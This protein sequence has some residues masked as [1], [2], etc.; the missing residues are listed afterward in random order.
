M[1]RLPTDPRPAPIDSHASRTPTQEFGFTR[2]LTGSRKR[3]IQRASHL[4]LRAYGPSWIPCSRQLA[5]YHGHCLPGPF[6][7]DS[8][9]RL[10][11]GWRSPR[12]GGATAYRHRP[13]GSTVR[14]R[15]K[16]VERRPSAFPGP[17]SPR[18]E[19]WCCSRGNRFLD[20]MEPPL[21]HLQAKLRSHL[22]RNHPRHQ[23]LI[24][25]VL[26]NRQNRR[27]SMIQSRV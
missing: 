10:S 24:T 3:P 5:A 13:Q 1:P 17:V 27:G 9:R 12:D 22:V 26:I 15:Q 14:A 4:S 16:V 20:A 7:P 8:W 23:R 18:S 6:C 11:F 2:R 25:P 19:Q 21:T